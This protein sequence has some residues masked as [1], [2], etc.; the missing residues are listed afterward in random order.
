MNYP[1]TLAEAQK[2]RYGCWAGR[3]NGNS[4]DSDKCA[5]EV[6]G[7]PSML[8]RQCYRT[9]GHGLNKLF[10]YQHAQ[11]VLKEVES[12]RQLAAFK[13][14]NPNARIHR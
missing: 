6:F 1:T 8:S 11:V 3:P 5:Y 14:R 7:D 13:S 9:N 10:C 2:H 12:K 4:Y